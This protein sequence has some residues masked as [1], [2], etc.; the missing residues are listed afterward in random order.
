MKTASAYACKAAI[1][2]GNTE[3]VS[4][5]AR[6]GVWRMAYGNPTTVRTIAPIFPPSS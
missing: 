4:L 5:K 1:C 2:E 3:I 6:D